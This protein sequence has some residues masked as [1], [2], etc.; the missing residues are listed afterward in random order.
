MTSGKARRLPQNSF[1]AICQNSLIGA[2]LFVRQ[3]VGMPLYF[4]HTSGQR[5]LERDDVGVDLADLDAVRAEAA[6]TVVGFARDA[7]LT[8][9]PLPG[10][11]FEVM[12]AHGRYLLTIPF[13][14]ASWVPSKERAAQAEGLEGAA[15]LPEHPRSTHGSQK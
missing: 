12:D 3:K 10:R 4:F 15:L 1:F 8:G 9:Q 7:E 6:K 5:G 13:G 11:A 14:F 2:V